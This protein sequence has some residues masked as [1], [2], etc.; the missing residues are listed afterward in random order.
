M[1]YTL[2]ARLTIV[3]LRGTRI[4]NY[5]TKVVYLYKQVAIADWPSVPLFYSTVARYQLIKIS[6]I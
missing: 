6:I 5:S 2:S 4:I 3:S 1:L